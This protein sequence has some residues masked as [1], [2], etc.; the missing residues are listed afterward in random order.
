M[1]K[2]QDALLQH[3]EDN[4]NFIQPRTRRNEILNFVREG[5]RDLSISRTSFSSWGL[6]Y[7]TT[8]NT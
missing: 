1:S 5:L 4:P 8:S 7:R 2:Y 3:I 6:R